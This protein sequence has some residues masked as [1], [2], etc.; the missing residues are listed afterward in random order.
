MIT[1]TTERVWCVLQSGP[2]LDIFSQTG[3]GHGEVRQNNLGWGSL[4][5]LW[6]GW[7][8]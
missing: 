2:I 6:T 1:D 8:M 5:G 7:V 4:K 3:R